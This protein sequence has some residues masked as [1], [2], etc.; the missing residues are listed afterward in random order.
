M[1]VSR[2]RF[3]FTRKTMKN[4]I[5]RRMHRHSPQRLQGGVPVLFSPLQGHYIA[6]SVLLATACGTPKNVGPKPCLTAN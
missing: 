6:G 2:I 5:L 1:L 3:F 4:G